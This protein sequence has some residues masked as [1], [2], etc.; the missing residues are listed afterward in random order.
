M[1]DIFL[2]K[3]FDENGGMKTLRST[4]DVEMNTEKVNDF[5]H[6]AGIDF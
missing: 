4:N 5:I 2:S 6:S 1:L 3:E